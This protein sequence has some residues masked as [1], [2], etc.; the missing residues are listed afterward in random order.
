MIWKG[1]E[2]TSLVSVAT[3]KIV[4]D[5]LKRNGFN[6][7]FTLCQGTGQSVG[8]HLIQ[9]K[10]LGLVCMTGSTKT[11][12]HVATTVAGRFGKTILELG[13]N[14]ATI[15]MEDADLDM[16]VYASVYGASAT[17]G[18][19]CSALRRLLVQDSVFNEMKAKMVKAYS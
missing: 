16:A 3:S 4:T 1:H 10:R 15:V 19:R 6:S 8:E 12:R 2:D 14:N 18:Q 7:V 17:T 11:G 13:G 9:D 5:V